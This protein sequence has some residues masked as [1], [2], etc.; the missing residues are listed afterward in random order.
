MARGPNEEWD[1][2]LTNLELI[3]TG[4][5]SAVI[6]DDYEDRILEPRL[7]GG[8]LEE[9]ADGVVRISYPALTIDQFGVDFARWPGVGRWLEVVITK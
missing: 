6:G 9:G 7:V 3:L 5:R 8:G 2:V 4:D 1:F